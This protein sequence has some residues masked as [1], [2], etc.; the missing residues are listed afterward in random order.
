VSEVEAWLAHIQ[1]SHPNWRLG[2][3]EVG[4]CWEAVARPTATATHVVV[5]RTLRELATRLAE[6]EGDHE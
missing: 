3:T 2:A 1:R 6:L 4:A 5:R